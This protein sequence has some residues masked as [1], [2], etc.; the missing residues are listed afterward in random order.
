MLNLKRILF[1]MLSKNVLSTDIYSNW[2]FWIYIGPISFF[3]VSTKHTYYI[4]SFN[5]FVNG[6]L[7]TKKLAHNG[8]CIDCRVTNRRNTILSTLR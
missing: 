2:L 4:I 8:H 1:I 7:I 5:G 6:G 3:F